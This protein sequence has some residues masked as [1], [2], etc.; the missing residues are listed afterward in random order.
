MHGAASFRLYGR[1]KIGTYSGC[2]ETIV[3]VISA[4]RLVLVQIAVMELRVESRTLSSEASAGIL[5]KCAK[6]SPTSSQSAL[7]DHRVRPPW[8]D[9]LSASNN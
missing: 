9:L 2:R 5:E 3:L 7:G 8:Y 6:L 4:N 1:V